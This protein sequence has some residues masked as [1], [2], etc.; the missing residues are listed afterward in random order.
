MKKILLTIAIVLVG[1]TLKSQT[2][3]I[4]QVKNTFNTWIASK[5]KS[6]SSTSAQLKKVNV[7]WVLTTDKPTLE[8]YNKSYTWKL[9]L[10]SS[11][12]QFVVLDVEEDDE[13]YKYG[14]SYVF[15]DEPTYRRFAEA[16]KQGN[17]DGVV[18]SSNATTKEAS[19]MV[20]GEQMIFL[21]SKQ[22]GTPE[23]RFEIATKY[24]PKK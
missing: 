23:Y 5:G 4:D 12:S 1:A 14:I 15:Y 21:F 13:S 18:Q 20:K 16:L 7:K 2:L 9:H 19:L 24:I 10:T 11:S 8:E 17:P 22:S 6:L 3:T